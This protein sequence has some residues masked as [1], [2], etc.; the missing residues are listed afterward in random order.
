MAGYTTYG[1]QAYLGGKKV[2]TPGTKKAKPKSKKPAPYNKSFMGPQSPAQMTAAQQHNAQ[3]EAAYNRANAQRMTGNIAATQSYLAAQDA[4][5]K[6]KQA[7]GL[8]NPYVS[9][10]GSG[11]GGYSDGG[12]AANLAAQQADLGQQFEG[13]KLAV[14]LGSIDFANKL[15]ALRAQN[16]AQNAQIGQSIQGDQAARLAAYQ[17]AL[18]NTQA[19]LVNSGVNAHALDQQNAAQAA[20]YK[21]AAQRQSQLQQTLQQVSNTGLTDRAAG[22]HQYASSLIGGIDAQKLAA[23][24]SLAASAASGGGGGGGGRSGG[25]GGSSS[26]SG[27]TT[28]TATDFGSDTTTNTDGTQRVDTEKGINYK[29]YFQSKIGASGQKGRDTINT[30]I[31][32]AQKGMS[33]GDQAAYWTKIL[34]KGGKVGVSHGQLKKAIKDLMNQKSKNAL[35]SSTTK[36]TSGSKNSSKSGTSGTSKSTR[37]S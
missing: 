10:G 4:A 20:A 27:S 18:G 31:R 14:G 13:A 2:N 17:S 19:D 25:S 7:G 23:L 33:A 29:D 30:M 26:G 35:N 9:G 1:S 32:Q 6:A 5:A 8:P 3:A 24:Q 28:D 15:A 21:D 36:S 22:Q 34:K 12:Y 16:D 37:K 11:G